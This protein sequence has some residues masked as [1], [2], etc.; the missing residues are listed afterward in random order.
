MP[1][2]DKR[3]KELTQEEIAAEKFRTFFSTSVAQVPEAMSRR[4]EEETPPKRGLFGGLFQR[5][6]P[7]PETKEPAERGL[8]LPPTGEI[9]LGDDAEEPQ[10]DLELVLEPEEAAAEQPVMPEPKKQTVPATPEKAPQEPAKPEAPAPEPVKPAEPEKPAAPAK[11]AEPVKKEKPENKATA[12]APS[13]KKKKQKL[14]QP[15]VPRS[16]ME[17]RE[18]E[19]MKELKAMLFGKPK[20][21]AKSAPKQTETL[22]A[23]PL[24]GLVFAEDKAAPE[25]PKTPAEPEKTP[26][27][28]PVTPQPTPRMETAA[29]PESGKEK[30]TEIPA[31][32]FF[33]KADDEVKA[34]TRET[35]PGP[36]DSMSLPLIGLDNE[37]NPSEEPPVEAL[38]AAPAAEASTAEVPVDGTPAAEAEPASEEAPATPEEVGEKLRKMGAALTLRCVLGGILAA[39]LLHFGLVAEG[40]LAPLAALDPVV[41]PAAFYAA[42]LLFLAAAMAVAA[43]VLRD[44]L[45]GLKK[46]GRPSSDT[47]PA[48]AACAAL[49]EAVVALLNAQSYQTSSFTILS[50]IAALGLFMALLG[51]R[52]QLA[53]GRRN[54]SAVAKHRPPRA[55]NRRVC[56]GSCRADAHPGPNADLVRKLESSGRKAAAALRPANPV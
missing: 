35:A 26:E 51:S 37:G 10:A 17:Q 56:A 24:T 44:G 54:R 25:P 8:E 27:K 42:N 7:E 2:E 28:P 48:L 40:L 52:V 21:P 30:T 16:A 18:D 33:G 43:P 15:A 19:E 4:E 50:G 13:N 31:F 12:P 1:K 6:K 36:D 29:E 32:R 38:K 9:V 22:P 5:E 49:L 45:L 14:D 39:V 20:A 53:A 23:S 47:M 46:D 11:P 55:G 34:P 41:A 3:R